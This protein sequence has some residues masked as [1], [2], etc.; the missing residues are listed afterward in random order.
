MPYKKKAKKQTL[1]KKVNKLEKIVKAQKPETKYS[2][3]YGTLLLD[4]NPTAFLAPYRSVSQGILDI[5]NRIGDNIHIN[6]VKIKGFFSLPAASS[7]TTARV[8]A[9]IYKKNPDVVI[10]SFATIINLYLNST[11]MNSNQAVNSFTDWDNH[12]AFSTIYDKK[13]TVNPT[14]ATLLTE[15]PFDLTI[16]IPKSFR[17]VKYWNGGIYPSENE[18]IVGFISDSDSLLYYNYIWRM[19][20]TDS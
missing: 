14:T 11:N 19:T 10:T 1:T 9:F 16:N 4:N 18:L 20:Y 6:S 17:N 8:V 3:D 5:N 15:K 2:S 13:F 12:P 7:G